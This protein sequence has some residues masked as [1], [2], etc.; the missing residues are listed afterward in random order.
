MRPCSAQLRQECVSRFDQEEGIEVATNRLR[1][2]M[3]EPAMVDRHHAE[4][5]RLRSLHH[6]HIVSFHKVWLDCDAGVLKFITEF[7]NSGSLT[8]TATA[9]ST[10]P[11]RRSRSGRARSSRASTSTT[12][13]S[14]TATLIAATS[15]ST[16]SPAM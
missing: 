3:L 10:S 7:C 8:S 13:A 12:P 6:D 1:L 16:A 2:H 11:S 14:S 5:H 15:S 4:V 9:K